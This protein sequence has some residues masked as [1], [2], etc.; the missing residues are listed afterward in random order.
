MHHQNNDAPH[1]PHVL[2]EICDMCGYLL[3]TKHHHN[4][5]ITHSGAIFYTSNPITPF[6]LATASKIDIDCK[7]TNVMY[8]LTYLYR[9]GGIH[10]LSLSLAPWTQWAEQTQQRG[11]KGVVAATPLLQTGNIFSKRKK[12]DKAKTGTYLYTCFFSSLS[13]SLGW[14]KSAASTSTAQPMTLPSAH[15]YYLPLCRY[16]HT[17]IYTFYF[18]ILSSPSSQSKFCAA[19]KV[20]KCIEEAFSLLA[21]VSVSHPKKSRVKGLMV[22]VV[23]LLGSA[24]LMLRRYGV[25]HSQV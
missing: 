17:N 8:I 18:F 3:L 13:D 16:T 14:G 6:S 12:R 11:K 15:T 5:M 20:K 2:C 21:S 10:W 7:C 22:M 23:M 19:V 24:M 1:F 9:V 25:P 4:G